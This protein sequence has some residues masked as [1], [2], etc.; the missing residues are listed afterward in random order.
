MRTA[1]GI[2]LSSATRSA[3]IPE[4]A[5]A[6]AGTS[7]PDRVSPA[8]HSHARCQTCSAHSLRASSSAAESSAVRAREGTGSIPR[9]CARLG[10][11][12]SRTALRRSALPSAARHGPSILFEG[13]STQGSS[14]W[15]HAPKVS[16]RRQFIRGRIHTM[17]PASSRTLI[18]RR[19]PTPEPRARRKRTVSAWS[20][21]VCPKKM[22]TRSPKVWACS[23]SALRRA[24]RA[25]ASGP[26]GASTVTL[27]HELCAPKEAITSH[28]SWA[29]RS[30][31]GRIP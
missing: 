1:W 20:S 15:R 18:A 5:S 8:A 13:S 17:L 30:E 29:S 2:S 7:G 11:A 22:A 24:T 23:A 21:I 31:P 14:S 28:V 12:C 19:E 4:A 27:T 16:L 25:E 10:I 3:P 6:A 9:L 26:P